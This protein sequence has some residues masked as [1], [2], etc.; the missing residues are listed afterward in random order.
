MPCRGGGGHYTCYR[1]NVRFDVRYANATFFPTRVFNGF[2]L[3]EPSGATT[4]VGTMA[5]MLTT[6]GP[7]PDNSSLVYTYDN[8]AFAFGELNIIY[9]ATLD[10]NK[11]LGEFNRAIVGGTG[12]FE[13]ATGGQSMCRAC[14][15]HASALVP[16]RNAAIALL[17][18]CM[19]LHT[20]HTNATVGSYN[21][22]QANGGATS[23]LRVFV[24]SLPKL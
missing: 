8:I 3:D 24:P 18:T 2:M 14:A 1:I 16:L 17:A 4:V 22:V 10:N 21:R 7:Q 12:Y 5:G 23:E 13:G 20:H 15:M 19:P 6:A 11:N 9:V